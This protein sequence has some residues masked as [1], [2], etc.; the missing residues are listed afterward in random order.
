MLKN[1]HGEAD[2]NVW[3]HC[4]SSISSNIILGSDTDIWVYGMAFMGCGWLGNKT[5]YVER[6]IGS[7][8]VCLNNMFEAVMN[9]PKLKRIPFPL[10]SLATVYILIGGDY[11]SSF[12][13]TSK[14]TFLTIHL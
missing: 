4:M 7:E 6:A 12:F 2:Y 11:I 10:L 14:Q 5:V 1:K 8:Y 9:H 3:Y 13:R